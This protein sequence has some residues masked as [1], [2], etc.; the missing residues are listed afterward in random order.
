MSACAL[1]FGF[2]TGRW[3]SAIR[4]VNT[5]ER[6]GGCTNGSMCS[7]RTTLRTRSCRVPSV[8]FHPPAEGGGPAL[9]VVFEDPW[10]HIPVRPGKHFHCDCCSPIVHDVF[11]RCFIRQCCRGNPPAKDSRPTAVGIERMETGD[12]LVNLA[13]Q[14]WQLD[15]GSL[16]EL[17]NLS[18]DKGIMVT[19]RLASSRDGNADSD[20]LD[21]SV[22]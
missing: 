10:A 12:F 4:A 2:T 17:F 3:M 7:T 19:V 9:L 8:G 20:L 16:W 18:T 22:H 1:A 14:S 5:A 6:A 13:L 11:S 15:A 21:L